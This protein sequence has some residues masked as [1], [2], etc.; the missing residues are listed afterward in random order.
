MG[1]LNVQGKVDYLV[2]GVVESVAR[3]CQDRITTKLEMLQFFIAI[4]REKNAHHSGILRQTKET[5][6]NMGRE[7]QY[8]ALSSARKFCERRTDL[9]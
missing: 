7:G 4:R 5:Q 2:N 3:K 6:S 1:F 9:T 8:R